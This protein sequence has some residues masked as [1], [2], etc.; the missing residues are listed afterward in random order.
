MPVTSILAHFVPSQM[1]SCSPKSMTLHGFQDYLAFP[2]LDADMTNGKNSR[3][4]KS[5]CRR[6]AGYM[7]EMQIIHVFARTTIAFLVLYGKI[8]VR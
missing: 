7:D 5:D 4:T 3:H 8:I 2:A 1:S 6:R